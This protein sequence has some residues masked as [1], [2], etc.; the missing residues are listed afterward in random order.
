[1]WAEFKDREVSDI[2]VPP[3]D[4]DDIAIPELHETELGIEAKKLSDTAVAASK[5]LSMDDL[6]AVTEHYLKLCSENSVEV[7]QH[8]EV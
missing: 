1:M 3:E 5:N 6:K 2:V 7:E 8:A 4:E